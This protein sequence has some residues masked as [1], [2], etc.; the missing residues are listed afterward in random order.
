VEEKARNQLL[1]SQLEDSCPYEVQVTTSD[2]KGAG[3]DARVYLEVYGMDESM[4]GSG[5][6]RLLDLDSDVAPFQ[7]NGADGFTVS[8]DLVKRMLPRHCSAQKDGAKSPRLQLG[9]TFCEALRS[10]PHM[11]YPAYAHSIQGAQDMH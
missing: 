3:T 11:L 10:I 6:A 8:A 2:I 5:E 4:G 1:Q 7:R 9:C